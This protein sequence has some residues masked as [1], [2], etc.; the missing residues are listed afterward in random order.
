M[1]AEPNVTT[2]TET[3]IAALDAAASAENV[4]RREAWERDR[5]AVERMGNELVHIQ[6]A[7]APHGLSIADLLRS[8]AKHFHGVTVPIYSPTDKG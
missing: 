2:A 1:T 6:A 3:E 5:D 8:V 4:A 7:L